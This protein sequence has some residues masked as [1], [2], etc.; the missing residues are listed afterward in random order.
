[1]ASTLF[2]TPPTS[3]YEDALKEFIESERLFIDAGGWKE[4]LLYIAK[5]SYFILLNLD[6]LFCF[7][8]YIALSKMV[9]AVDF[10]RKANAA[11]TTGADV[12]A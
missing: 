10:L 7:K 11:L 3:S 1:M 9:E 4:N 12:S 8:C 2:A 6:L 5:V